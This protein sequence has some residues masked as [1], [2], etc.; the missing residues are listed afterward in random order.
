MPSWISTTAAVAI[1]FPS[2]DSLNISIRWE[3]HRK[4]ITAVS[5]MS[6]SSTARNTTTVRLE[7]NPT[8]PTPADWIACTTSNGVIEE[9]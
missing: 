9:F 2:W 6:L 1:T 8:T 7:S 4:R 5:S 3:T